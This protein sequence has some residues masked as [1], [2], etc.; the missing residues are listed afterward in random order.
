[1]LACIS[2]GSDYVRCCCS[3]QSLTVI[4]LVSVSVSTG[5]PT[6]GICVCWLTHVVDR[7]S[8]KRSIV[9]RRNFMIPTLICQHLSPDVHGTVIKAP[10]NDRDL[11]KE[12]LEDKVSDFREIRRF[13]DTAPKGRQDRSRL[14]GR[15]TSRL[16]RERGT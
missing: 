14:P 12:E 11:W 1:M 8:G 3:Q 16:K 13:V 4:Q 6:R 9:V 15:K 7:N 5:F 2:H 10:A